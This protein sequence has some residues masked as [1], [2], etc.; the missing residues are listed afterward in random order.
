MHASIAIS[1]FLKDVF[2]SHFSYI[3]LSL[4]YVMFFSIKYMY[5]VKLQTQGNS[6]EKKLLLL[7]GTAVHALEVNHLADKF[8]VSDLR[9]V[10]C[11]ET[12]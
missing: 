2:I 6:F 8:F 10:F 7:F 1:N 5:S 9:M 4:V 11:L 12:N 3:A